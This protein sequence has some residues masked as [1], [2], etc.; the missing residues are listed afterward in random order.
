MPS[1]FPP[2]DVPPNYAFE[3]AV[4]ASVLGAA[5]A[6]EII[7]PAALGSGFPRPLNADVDMTFAVKAGGFLVVV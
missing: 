2:T 4:I 5:G 7:A 3:R 1:S 6:S